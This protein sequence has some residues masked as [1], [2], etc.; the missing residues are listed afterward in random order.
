MAEYW[1]DI[2]ERAQATIAVWQVHFAGLTLGATDLAAF[3]TLTEALPG[4]AQTRDDRQQDLDGARQARDFAAQ[5]LRNVA[6]R[7]PKIIE[8]RLDPESG[9]I[10]D[11]DKVYAI[12]P[13]SFDK[14]EARGRRLLPVWNSANTWLAAQVPPQEQVTYGAFDADLFSDELDNF[15]LLQAVANAGERDDAG[16]DTL[17][18][19][20]RKVEKLCIRFLKVAK[21]TAEPG[22]PAEASLDTIPT[23]TESN[24]PDTLRILTF[25]QGGVDGLQ[26][27]AAYAPYGLDPGETAILQYQRLDIDAD[28]QSVPYDA[29]GNA[30][31]PFE[32]GQTVKARTR[33]TNTSGSRDGSVRQL[34]LIAPYP[35]GHAS[36]PAC[37]YPPP[38][39][40]GDTTRP[41][42]PDIQPRRGINPCHT[43]E[44]TLHTPTECDRGDQLALR[45]DFSEEKKP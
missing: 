5:A 1:Q 10:D 45:M 12:Q 27:L 29:S 22:S 39:A 43:T 42:P 30:I 2:Q 40:T 33:V 20:A 35:A 15:G 7:V 37:A 44:S 4:Q 18:G 16:R 28:W 26:L 34:T 24:L 6:M 25:S 9:V 32:V 36:G 11:L 8:G 31:G 38:G 13:R 14:I 21:G 19:A 41:P 3:E 23:T 17:N